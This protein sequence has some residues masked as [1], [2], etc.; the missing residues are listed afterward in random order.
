MGRVFEKR[1]HKMFARFAK[2]AKAFTKLGREIVIAVKA[3]GTDPANNS[4]L[5][6]VIANARSVNMPKDRIDAAIKRANDKDTSN[7]EEIIYE[8]KAPHGIAVLVECTT[9]NPTRTV[10]NIRMY[11]NRAEGELGKTGSVAFMFERKGMFK[12]SAKGLSK[13]DLELELIDAGCEEITFDDETDE[14]IIQSS[15]NDFGLMQKALEDKNIEVINASKVF[16]ANTTKEITEEQENDVM[17]MIEK[18]E[19]DDDVVA[20]YT[21]VG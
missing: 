3:G 1:K 4:R 5:R 9:D 10:A 12:I 15:F 20:V 14:L 16:F 21:N 17:A 7:Y 19:D 8:G 6:Q 11:F 18:M 2:M 13:D